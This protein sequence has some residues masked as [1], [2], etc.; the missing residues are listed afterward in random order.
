MDGADKTLLG[1][2]RDIEEGRSDDNPEF[3]GRFPLEV[4]MEIQRTVCFELFRPPP[5]SAPPRRCR[6]T[7]PPSSR[8]APRGG[9][10][11]AGGAAD[12]EDDGAPAD[13]PVRQ[14]QDGLLH[15]VVKGDRATDVVVEGAGDLRIEAL[16]RPTRLDPLVDVAHQE[17]LLMP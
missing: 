7:R 16:V 14:V 10:G 2:N 8:A 6:P 15:G 12:V 13:E 11:R 4:V 1:I 5:A 3:L 17:S 9:Q